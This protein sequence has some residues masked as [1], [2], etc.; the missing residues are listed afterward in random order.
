VAGTPPFWRHNISSEIIQE[1]Y[2]THFAYN[3][4]I[5]EI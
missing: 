2:L 3:K 5:E 1:T 4:K